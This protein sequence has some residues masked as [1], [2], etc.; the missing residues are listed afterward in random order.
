MKLQLTFLLKLYKS[1]DWWNYENDCYLNI[2]KPQVIFMQRSNIKRSK[3]SN[4]NGNNSTKSY[5]K[6]VPQLSTCMILEE[7]YLTV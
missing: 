6:Y 3:K 7:K 2:G 5:W 4:T 1:T